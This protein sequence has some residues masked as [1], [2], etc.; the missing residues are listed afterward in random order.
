M[1]MASPSLSPQSLSRPT[2]SSQSPSPPS[3]PQAVAA[4]LAAMAAF[5]YVGMQLLLFVTAN[6][7]ALSLPHVVG[8]GAPPVSRVEQWHMAQVQAVPP[9]PVAKMAARLQP[10][11]SYSVLAAELDTAEADERSARPAAYR[12]RLAT[13]LRLRSRSIETAAA[14]FNRNFGVIP[15]ASN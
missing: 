13:S 3:L 2:P 10:T 4:Y 15:V 8:R 6:V 7:I 9:M 11:E 12:P 14:A 5:T 1:R